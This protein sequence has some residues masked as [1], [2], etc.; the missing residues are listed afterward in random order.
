M[1]AV[2]GILNKQAVA[3]AADS[4][5]TIGGING[6]KIFNQANKVFAL[7]KHHPIGVM[8]YNSASFMTTPWETIIKIYRKQLDNKSFSTLKEYQENFISYLRSKDFFSNKDDQKKHFFAFAFTLI[9]SVISEV[10]KENPVLLETLSEENKQKVLINIS[11][12]VESYIIQFNSPDNL[13]SDFND[14][15]FEEYIDFAGDELEKIIQATFN[16]NGYILSDDLR[17]K[18]QQLS[19]L[20]LRTK[21]KFTNFTGLIFTGFGEEEIYPSLIPVNI[22]LAITHRLRFF[23]EENSIAKISNS[24]NGAIAPFAQTDVISTI[25]TGVDPTLDSTYLNNF[26]AAFTKYNNEILTRI[27]ILMMNLRR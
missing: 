3:I 1:T 16:N 17:M 25:L 10:L 4:A 7:S 2:V 19:F 5:V 20:Y 8:I 14:Y 12:K 24:N 23:I 11:T 15:T 9:N 6:K 18:L 27:G 26:E 22:S 13:C 21:E